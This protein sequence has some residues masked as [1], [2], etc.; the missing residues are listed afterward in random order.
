MRPVNGDGGG[1]NRNRYGQRNRQNVEVNDYKRIELNVNDK[2]SS[3]LYQ[4]LPQPFIHKKQLI[5]FDQPLTY[6][7]SR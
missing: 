1:A 3:S 4:S 6:L 2:V 7:K 5:S